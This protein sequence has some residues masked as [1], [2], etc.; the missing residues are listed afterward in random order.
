MTSTW[1]RL[2]VKKE[3]Q[4]SLVLYS[5]YND[6]N[7]K[8]EIYIFKTSKQKILDFYNYAFPV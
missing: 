4:N 7:R 1:C 3:Y 8:E 6:A 5:P 2:I